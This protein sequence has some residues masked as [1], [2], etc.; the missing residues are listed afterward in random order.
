MW[1]LKLPPA[2]REQVNADIIQ[3]E[4]FSQLLPKKLPLN[5][6]LL[7]L[8]HPQW[9]FLHG[10]GGFCLPAAAGACGDG[11]P[12]WLGFAVFGDA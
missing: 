9:L 6:C 2:Q 1:L 7:G 3:Q 5:V 10:S 8:C 11:F 4:L 12:L